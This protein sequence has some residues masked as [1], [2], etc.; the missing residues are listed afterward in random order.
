MGNESYLGPLLLLSMFFFFAFLPLFLTAPFAEWMPLAFFVPF[1]VGGWLPLLAYLSALGR[2]FRAPLIFALILMSFLIPRLFGDGYGVR[3]VADESN[4]QAITIQEALRL[5]RL[6]NCKDSIDTCPRP[7]IIAGAGGASR[8]GFFLAS[9]IGAFMDDTL[10]A[11]DEKKNLPRRGHGLQPEDIRKRIFAFSTVSGSSVGAVMATSA[12][13]AAPRNEMPCRR[14]KVRF[15]HWD[16]VVANWRDCL[17]ALMADDYLTP[18]FAG[19]MFRDTIRFPGRGDRAAL[20]EQSWEHHFARTIVQNDLPKQLA[21]EGS[22]QCPFRTLRPT[23][24]RWLPLLVLNGTSVQTGQR[25][26]TSILEWPTESD[27]KRTPANA[28]INQGRDYS[29]PIFLNTYLFHWLSGGRN[30]RNDI[31]L[32]TAAHNSARFPLVSPPGEIFNGG[33]FQD[34]IVDGGYYENYGLT[35]ALELAAAIQA[36]EPALAPFV[37]VISNDPDIPEEFDPAMAPGARRQF[38][39]DIVA[40]LGTIIHARSA[41]GNLAV[42]SLE[43]S[44]RPGVTP[45]CETSS[46]HIRVWPFG[47]ERQLTMSWWLSRPVQR[48]LNAQ[49]GAGDACVNDPC[50]ANADAIRALLAALT[51]P[52]ACRG[53]KGGQEALQKI[54]MEEIERGLAIKSLVQKMKTP[55]LREQKQ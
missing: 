31:R 3:P 8:A 11:P 45:D 15:W 29:C 53:N 42:A 43:Q 16:R 38:A 32:S 10:S 27:A 37:L 44:L 22:L 51:R 28:C 24:Q 34:R 26:V 30:T 48:Y 40:P 47:P 14:D 46:A 6:A 21:C 55:A 17:E 18:A 4:A 20:L 23:E 19:F 7:I 13:A 9:V 5:W 2:R 39:T 49:I 25:I 36:V 54:R 1:V 33:Q 50:L 41:S 12:M 52:P 35:S